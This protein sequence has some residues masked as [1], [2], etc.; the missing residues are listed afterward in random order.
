MA[1]NMFSGFIQAGQNR[2]DA[3]GQGIGALAQGY[4]DKK[5]AEATTQKQQQAMQL[6]DRASQLSDTDPQ[7][8]QQAFMQAIQIAPDFVSQVTGMMKQRREAMAAGQ[9]KQMTPYQS[10]SLRLREME[11][12]LKSEDNSLRREK[13]KQDIEL[14]KAKVEKTQQEIGIEAQAEERSNSQAISMAKEARDLAREIANDDGLSSAT[15]SK[16]YVAYLPTTT[17]TSDLVNK[18][19]RLQSMLTV[20]N[21]NLMV[22][23]LTDRDI[24][25]LTA[26]SSGLD[27]DPDKRGIVGSEKAVRKRLNDIADKIDQKLSGMK[28]EESKQEVVFDSPK[29]GKVTEADILETMRATG[30]TRDQV[31]NRIRSN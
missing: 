3:I 17:S 26:V 18:A 13:L 28:T 25:F 23:V 8:S 15:G 12:A 29:Y 9:P 1:G 7:A 27:I 22:G 30:M 31:I 16:A 24:Q 6:L 10:E 14:Q 11:A 5:A 2:S 21:L 20:D 4:Q 19:F